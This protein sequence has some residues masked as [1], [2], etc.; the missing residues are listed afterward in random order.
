MVGLRFQDAIC[1]AAI[2]GFQLG[3]SPP[4][5]AAGKAGGRARRTSGR[6]KPRPWSGGFYR[7][8]RWQRC[9]RFSRPRRFHPEEQERVLALR[10]LARP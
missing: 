10:R 3:R 7:L 5:C 6:N 2:K 9:I 8:A 4:D 1:R